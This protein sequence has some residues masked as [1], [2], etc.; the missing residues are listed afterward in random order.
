MSNIDPDEIIELA[1]TM[2]A[3]MRMEDDFQ[4][5][6]NRLPSIDDLNELIAAMQTVIRLND[7]ARADV[8]L[9]PLRVES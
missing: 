5:V 4:E 7:D 8:R 1:E 3:V 6:L 9:L 2:Q